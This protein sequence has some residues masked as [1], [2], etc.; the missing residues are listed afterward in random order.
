MNH[1]VDK[2]RKTLFALGAGALANTLPAFAQAPAKA[3]EKIWRV[4]FLAFRSRA[5][6]DLSYLGGLLQGMR[7]H[8]YVEGRNLVIEWRF[9]DNDLA[10]CPVWLP[11]WCS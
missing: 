1:Y 5:S 11:N 10:L 9:A 3:P 7:E 2:R 6:M 4:G 8:G